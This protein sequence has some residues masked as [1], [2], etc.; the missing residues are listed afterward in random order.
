LSLKTTATI[1]PSKKV[2]PITGKSARQTPTV[3]DSAMFFG[4]LMPAFSSFTNSLI[5][6]PGLNVI[7]LKSEIKM[8]TAPNI[9]FIDFLKN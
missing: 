9:Q 6:F 7:I 1:N 3:S 4:Q 8:K 5:L 2:M